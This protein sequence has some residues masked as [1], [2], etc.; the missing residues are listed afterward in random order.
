VGGGGAFVGCRG[1]GRRGGTAPGRAAGQGRR[2]PG[3]VSCTAPRRRPP[4]VCRQP[5]NP[6]RTGAAPPPQEGLAQVCLVGSAT[7]LVRAKVE[8]N[9]PRRAGG[10]G[11]GVGGVRACDCARARGC[12]CASQ[13][14]RKPP[15]ATHTHTRT[16]AHA[17][18]HTRTHA[19]TQQKK[20][21]HPPPNPLPRKRGGA[22]AGYDK[23]WE[24]FLNAVF[25]AVVRHVDW[26]IVK[27]LVIA[28]PGFAKDGF[29]CAGGLGEGVWGAA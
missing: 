27:C 4:I 21:A 23:A 16:R 5:P 8:A 14:R 6:A 17:H 9:L 10:L 22:A 7:T 28:G 12:V 24:K 1:P 26:G 20:H 15:Q 25:E 29:R 3:P 18:T 11:G 19:R 2:A 13:D